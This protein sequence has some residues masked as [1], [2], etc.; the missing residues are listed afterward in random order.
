MLGVGWGG[1]ETSYTWSRA[2]KGSGRRDWYLR[3]QKGEEVA[4][5]GEQLLVLREGGDLVLH[6]PFQMCDWNSIEGRA[7][8]TIGSY[9]ML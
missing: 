2:S 7:L 5:P 3:G 4:G 8:A 9:V 1:G 6:D